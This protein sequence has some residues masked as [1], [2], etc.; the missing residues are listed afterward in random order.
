[1]NRTFFPILV[2]LVISLVC[3]AGEGNIFDRVQ[4]GQTKEQIRK[5][6]GEPHEIKLLMKQSGPIWG[7]E[8]EFWH[9]I[10]ERT[11]LEVWRYKNPQG[12]LNLYF[13]DGGNTLAYKAYA[14]K[15]VV[16]ESGK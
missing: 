8:E 5:K 12:Q 11:K 4:T 3:I 1:M 2:L 15:G 10:P 9:K 7:P 14:P 16:Y 13:M 6:L